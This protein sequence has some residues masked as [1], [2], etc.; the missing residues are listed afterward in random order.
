MDET[1]HTIRDK[2]KVPR[3][4]HGAVN[5]GA[6]LLSHILGSRRVISSNGEP[7]EVDD[8]LLDELVSNTDRIFFFFKS[9]TVRLGVQNPMW[10]FHMCVYKRCVVLSCN[11]LTQC[12]LPHNA[13]LSWR[14]VHCGVSDE[15]VGVAPG[16]RLVSGESVSSVCTSSSHHLP[17]LPPFCVA[18][19]TESCL[20]V[21]QFSIASFQHT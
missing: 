6:E 5:A 9:I 16:C 11:I 19:T 3:H 4:C 14:S 8:E 17:H 18:A 13:K 15:R 10:H 20:R 2:T 21:G 12:F 1:R 7:P